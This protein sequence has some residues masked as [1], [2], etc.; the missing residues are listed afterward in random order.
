MDGGREGE[1]VER[2]GES[3]EDERVLKMRWRESE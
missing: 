2:E 1:Y 3:E